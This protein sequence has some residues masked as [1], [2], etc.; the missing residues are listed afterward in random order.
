[1][2]HYRPISL[3]NVIYKIISKVLAERL[4]VYL[5]KCI[6]ESQS[7]FMSRRQILD[8]VVVAHECTYFINSHRKWKKGFMALKL[9]MAKAC[10]RVEWDFLGRV[11]EKMGLLGSLL[12]RFYNVLALF[13]FLLI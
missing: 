7:G 12:T 3:C 9:D 1:M 5:H 6:N 10:D 8:N 11:M 13:L 4:K 2:V